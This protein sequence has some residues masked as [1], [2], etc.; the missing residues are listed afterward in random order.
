VCLLRGTDCVF[1]LFQHFYR[2]IIVCISWNN[3]S[4]RDEVCLLRG[5]DWV[6]KLF[7]HFYRFIIVCI[8]CNNKKCSISWTFNFSLITTFRNV[9]PFLSRYNIGIVRPSNSLYISGLYTTVSIPN[10]CYTTFLALDN[11]LTLNNGFTPLKQI[12][13]NYQLTR[14]RFYDFKALVSQSINIA[15]Y[16]SSEAMNEGQ[17]CMITTTVCHKEL[18]TETNFKIHLSLFYPRLHKQERYRIRLI[19]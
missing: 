17:Y 9:S 19:Q 12:M 5:T 6:F 14:T 7:Q 13:G 15:F 3:K 2:F 4:D 11:F 18:N 8:S 16:P 10:C 1:K